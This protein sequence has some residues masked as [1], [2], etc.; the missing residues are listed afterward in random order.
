MIF[1]NSKL[2]MIHS[3]IKQKNKWLNCISFLTLS[4]SKILIYMLPLSY[5]V[6]CGY[7]YTCSFMS[8]PR[9]LYS[10]WA[11]KF[12]YCYFAD[13]KAKRRIWK[14][15]FQENDA[16]QIFR[17]T[18]ISNITTCT[19]AYQGVRNV[20]FLENLT[21]FVFLETPILRCALHVKARFVMLTSYIVKFI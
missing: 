10:E 20:R 13:N 14:R 6:S 7:M 8:I 1:G 12:K 4:V 21:C 17:I 9:N 19:C 16:R 11:L 15:V 18:N 5:F 3:E 2:W